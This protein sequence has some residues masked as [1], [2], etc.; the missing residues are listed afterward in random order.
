MSL[1]K[2]YFQPG[3]NPDSAVTTIASLAMAEIS[4]LPPGTLPPFVLKFD[5]S[6]LPVCLVTFKGEGLKET[7]LKDVAQ[8]NRAQPVGG[9]ARS[10]AVPQPFGG[11][12]RQMMLYVDP[13]KLESHQ[14][15]LMDV[16]RAMNESNPCCPPGDVQIGRYDYNI[17]ANSQ[18]P[19]VA[20]INRVPIKIVGRI[21]GARFRYRR[22]QGCIHYQYNAVRVDGQRSVYLP[23]LKQGGDSN[24]IQVVEGVQQE[25]EEAL[26][27]PALAGQRKWCSISRSSSRQPFEPCC[28][29]AASACFSPA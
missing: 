14:L 4:H 1:I 5:A 15:S 25:A 12:W 11:R 26:R 24:T 18:V 2:V 7:Q 17:Y 28:T 8:N 3:T 16:V 22:G 6:S 23:V 21:P 19:N 29:K 13:H 9:G 20:D 10:A 27:Y